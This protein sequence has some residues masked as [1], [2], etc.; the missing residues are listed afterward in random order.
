MLLLL[1]AILN[2]M[3]YEKKLFAFKTSF[4]FCI[5]LP[6]KSNNFCGKFAF[7]NNKITIMMKELI[8]IH[9]EFL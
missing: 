4:L 8:N 6:K 7:Y 3:G 9:V 1:L 2:L 5:K